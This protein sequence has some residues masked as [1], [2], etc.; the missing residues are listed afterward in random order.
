MIAIDEYTEEK[1]QDT[2]DKFMLKGA[3]L[4]MNVIK[5]YEKNNGPLTRDNFSDFLEKNY[6]DLLNI[7]LVKDIYS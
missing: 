4:Y 2:F 3:E 6:K 5:K 1:E 7:S